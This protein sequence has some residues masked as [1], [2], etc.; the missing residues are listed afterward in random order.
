MN[1]ISKKIIKGLTNL[2]FFIKISTYCVFSI[3]LILYSLLTFT[4]IKLQIFPTI[5]RITYFD[6]VIDWSLTGSFSFDV[7]I[8]LG[9]FIVGLNLFFKPRVSISFSIFFRISSASFQQVFLRLFK[10]FVF[11]SPNALLIRLYEKQL[12]ESIET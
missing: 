11:L 3:Y 2:K 9:L 5:N 12:I 8:T 10:G 6:A 1:L 7:A 4:L